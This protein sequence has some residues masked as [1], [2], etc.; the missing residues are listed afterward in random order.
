MLDKTGTVTRED[1]AGRRRRSQRRLAQ[2]GASTCR[3]GRGR[4]EHPIGSAI[5]AAARAE[6]GPLPDV[7]VRQQAGVGSRAGGGQRRRD[8][9]RRRR[10]RGRGDAMP[11]ARL[12]V[13]DTVKATS[14]QGG[15]G[16][17]APLGLD[18][19]L[20]TSDRR[21]TASAIAAEVGIGTYSPRYP[22]DKVREIERAAGRRRGGGDGRR[23]CQ[24]CARAR[25][26]RPGIAIGTGTDVAIE[27]SDLTLVS[28]I[29]AAAVTQSPAR[30]T[31]RTIQTNPFWAFAYNVADSTRGGRT[32]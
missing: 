5:A 20:L 12:V 21:E 15:R 3:R 24:R 9:P 31:L 7:R 13:R 26:G 17:S 1:G 29:R 19:V 28:G 4:L 11:V 16:A 30:R 10:R 18:P 8:R 6:L 27:A 25:A 22:G 14:G 2:G 32:S 23:R